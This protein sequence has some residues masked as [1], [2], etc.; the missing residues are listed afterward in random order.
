LPANF[1]ITENR[2]LFDID[3]DASS[4]KSPTQ[5]MPATSDSLPE[6]EKD[7]AP[8]LPPVYSSLF[9]PE[10][11][12][13]DRILCFILSFLIPFAG[14]AKYPPLFQNQEMR[15]CNEW[16]RERL[17]KIEQSG[18]PGA[19]SS[20]TTTTCNEMVESSLTV[21]RRPGL[22]QEWGVTT[23][24][25]STD[26]NRSPTQ[27]IL[28]HLFLPKSLVSTE[29]LSN[30]NARGCIEVVSVNLE[31]VSDDVPIIIFFHGGG[32]TTGSSIDLTG[33]TLFAKLLEHQAK[34]NGP[35]CAIFAS[36]DYS[37]APDFPFP[38]A[39][40]DAVTAVA[41]FLDSFPN[42]IIHIAGISAGATLAAIS[43]A[44]CISRY[45]D[46]IASTLSACPMLKPAA[47]TVSYYQNRDMYHPPV[48]WLRWSWRAYLQFEE[49]VSDAEDVYD[50]LE[51]E[52]SRGSNRG[53][54][55]DFKRDK[56][57]LVRLIRPDLPPLTANLPR[58]I[59]TTNRADPLYSE[60][61]EYVT[62][63][64]EAGADVR[65]LD[66]GGSHWL[67]TALN[68]SSYQSLLEAWSDAVFG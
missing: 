61:V 25:T 18:F 35:C 54:W 37:L 38:S 7:D 29:E 20:Y 63:L 42:R 55:R 56:S 6:A 33:F 50:D 26:T 65:W 34:K 24:M 16:L 5:A 11:S 53:A 22:W 3:V 14:I 62:Q 48:E 2:R 47:D 45:P 28:V 52:F 17:S 19:V 30:K 1:F 49:S 58:F 31:A 46:R 13:A 66:C 43:T 59:V 21:P 41:Y 64:K 23:K 10:M 40:T 57:E 60:G 51:R 68:K 39:H 67:G 12:W 44:H 15:K 32:F 36:V 8:S 4:S 27:D 9:H